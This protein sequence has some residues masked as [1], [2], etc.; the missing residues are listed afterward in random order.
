[1]IP[2]IKPADRFG[3]GNDVE[4]KLEAETFYKEIMIKAG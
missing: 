4:E 2:K 3:D 1:M